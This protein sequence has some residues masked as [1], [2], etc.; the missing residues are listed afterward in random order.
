M[1]YKREF[2]NVK[3][4]RQVLWVGAEAYPLRNIARA[5]TVRIVPNRGAAIRRFLK[6]FVL[7]VILGIVAAVAIGRAS[8]VNSVQA[9][10]DLH[11]AAVAVL[12][13]A[14]VL[15]VISAVRLI[16]VLS[17]GSFYALIIETAGTPRSVL[18]SDDE[19][20]ISKLVRQIMDAIDNPQVTYHTTVESIDLRGAQGV[21]LG[22]SGN[23]NNT[24]NV[25]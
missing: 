16:R 10:N 9:S 5:Q 2:I 15:V 3:I 18:V 20:E 21:Q 6:A 1:S 12:V 13:L 7:E 14:V 17:K 23:Q 24:F 4:S 11:G 25:R 22:S 19:N 8:G